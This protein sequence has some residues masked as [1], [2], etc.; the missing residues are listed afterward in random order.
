MTVVELDSLITLF[1]SRPQSAEGDVA[2]ARERFEKLAQFIGGAPDSSVQK[3]DAGGVPA[4]WVTAEGIDEARTILYL[5][6][7]GYVI[8]SINTYLRL[9]YDLSAA[10]SARVLLI[11][12]RLAPE[13]P[14]PAAVDDAATAWRWLIATGCDPRRT[15]IVGD[16]AGGGLA[17]AT[18]VN[19][20]DKG[21]G[22]PACVVA[23]SPWVDLEGSGA[24]MLTRAE[25]D[26]LV[27]KES[28]LWLAGLYL[29]GADP[30]TPLA[31]PLYADLKGLPPTLILV[32]SAETLLDDALRIAEK[33]HADEVE[34]KLAV[35]PNMLHVWPV[36][37][38][39]L[40]EGRDGCLD[41]GHFIRT[42]TT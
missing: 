14:F 20:R 19:L 30:K 18:A 2:A 12:Y 37:A 31:A 35:W 38:P 15:A 7:G 8:G 32:G 39:K 21:L 34:V 42:K 41:A 4:A 1:R 16:S 27:Q 29:N 3:V 9:A 11:D 36:F 23:I 6:G 26:P 25:R 28:L 17:I 33:L 10:A 22:L 13:H 40:S 5:H 24:S